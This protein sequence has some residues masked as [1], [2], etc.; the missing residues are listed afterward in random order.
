MHAL[1]QSLLKIQSRDICSRREILS[2]YGNYV[3]NYNA[4]G[5]FPFITLW[6]CA[7]NGSVLCNVLNLITT[8]LPISHLIFMFVPTPRLC[9][10]GIFL[11]RL[12]LGSWVPPCNSAPLLTI[13]S[14]L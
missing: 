1:A 4:G 11:L 9:R 12:I 7:L 13:A 3:Y 2:C 5:F 6:G 8:Q 14:T 10:F